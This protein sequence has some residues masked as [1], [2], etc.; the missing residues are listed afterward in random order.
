MDTAGRTRADHRDENGRTVCF[1]TL[2]PWK[3]DHVAKRAPTG[4]YCGLEVRLEW[5]RLSSTV[6]G[7]L[8]LSDND[9]EAVKRLPGFQPFTAA[10][11]SP[12]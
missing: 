8:F 7:I 4:E 10:S 1:G 6:A 2:P 3:P 12:V 9:V 11:S 5:D